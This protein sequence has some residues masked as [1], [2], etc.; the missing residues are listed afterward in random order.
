M[1]LSGNVRRSDAN[2]NSNFT[3]EV[4]IVKGRNTKARGW[5]GGPSHPLREY[6]PGRSFV[7]VT[8]DTV[9]WAQLKL[10]CHQRIVRIIQVTE[11]GNNGHHVL[12]QPG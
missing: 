12:Q 6:L 10:D 1:T 11:V 4:G 2:E 5:N 3:R 8:Q 9:V 7:L